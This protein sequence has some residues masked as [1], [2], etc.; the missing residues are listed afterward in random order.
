[1]SDAFVRNESQAASEPDDDD[2][3]PAP[4]ARRPRSR[5]LSRQ[6]RL[7]LLGG[8]TLALAL[9]AGG[10]ALLPRV[11]PAY[12]VE[13]PLVQQTTDS[14]GTILWYTSR[15]VNEGITITLG[16]GGTA[17]PVE[18]DGRR[19]RAVLRDL[20][21]SQAYP[22]TIRLG[23][24]TLAAGVLHTNRQRDEPFSFA[25]FGDSG[26]GSR[27]QYRIAELVA[28]ARP[29]FVLH[30]GDLVYEGGERR[31]FRRR[32][33]EP[34]AR[35][36]ERVSFWPCLGNHDVSEP[37]FAAPYREV[38]ELPENGPAGLTPEH[39]YWFDYGAARFVVIDSNASEDDLRAKVAPWVLQTLSEPRL[40]W[41]FAA[42]H[43]PP[44][45]AGKYQPDERI[46][47]ALV[48]A[49]E[50]VGLDILFSG[51]DHIYLRTQPLRGGR[52]VPPGQGVVYVVTGAGGAELYEERRPEQRPAYVAALR[53]DVHSFTRV[54]IGAERLTLEQIDWNGRTLDRWELHKS[55]GVPAP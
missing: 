29:D 31:G 30:T 5:P 16:N 47:R 39:N 27:A 51:H 49:F 1:M 46:Q 50:Q 55:A 53:N 7:R 12:V 41:K 13:G 6:R 48:P 14:G 2:E 36:L 44:Y 4:A 19:H 8:M 20:N 15:R 25:V 54:S 23:E 45:T 22:Y 3:L 28:A 34:Y 10:Y 24:R 18:N 37:D 21:P 52:I 11:L 40:R 43:H 42:L 26:T 9:L 32:F 38:F 35:L 17:Q 33:F